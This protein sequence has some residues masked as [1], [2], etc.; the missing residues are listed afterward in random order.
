MI[1]TPPSGICASAP[2]SA[3]SAPKRASAAARHLAAREPGRQRERDPDERDHPFENSMM[4]CSLPWVGNG[5]VPQR[6]QWSQ[7]S[8][9]AVRRTKAPD[10]TTKNIAIVEP[11]ASCANPRGDVRSEIALG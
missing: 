5:A 6:G 1:V 11:A 8:P 4:A 3:P 2:R 10:V 7:P 9:D